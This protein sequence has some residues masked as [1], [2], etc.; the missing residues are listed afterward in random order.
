MKV[1]GEMVER[2]FA[3]L[4]GHSQPDVLRQALNI[5]LEAALKNVP[6]GY[7]W[8]AEAY[9]SDVEG[10]RHEER[11]KAAEAKLAKVRA[12]AEEHGSIHVDVVTDILDGE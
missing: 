4:G 1:T 5:A 6:D 2:A 12:H 8:M 10:M 3:A 11:A 7:R 9:N